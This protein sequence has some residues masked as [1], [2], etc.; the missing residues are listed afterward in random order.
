MGVRAA[1]A[2]PPKSGRP[3]LRDVECYN[4]HQRGHYASDCPQPS[5]R[6][7]SAGGEASSWQQKKSKGKGGQRQAH[8]PGGYKGESS[9]SDREDSHEGRPQRKPAGERVNMTRRFN[10]FDAISG[11]ESE[12]SESKE[13]VERSYC[14]RVLSGLAM[15]A[16][17]TEPA[18]PSPPLRRL[19][20]PGEVQ[21]RSEPQPRAAPAPRAP[22][23]PAAAAAPA[24]SAVP[25]GQ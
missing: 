12:A 11:D 21:P 17:A 20:R 19:K 5:R 6:K 9:D 23:A 14:A 13:D 24:A 3:A 25:D 18:S 8:P 2:A 1:S 10:R 22:A 16:A 15:M 4:C 7:P